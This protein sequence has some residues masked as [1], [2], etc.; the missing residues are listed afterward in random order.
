MFKATEVIQ[1]NQNRER[2]L[3]TRDSERGVPLMTIASEFALNIQW[4]KIVAERHSHGMA[5]EPKR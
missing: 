3:N 2:T 5:T 4:I 1:R